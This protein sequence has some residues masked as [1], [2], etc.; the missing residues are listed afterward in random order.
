MELNLKENLLV[1]SFR[2]TCVN[3]PNKTRSFLEFDKF[4]QSQIR[5]SLNRGTTKPCHAYSYITSSK[6]P[7]YACDD[8]NPHWTD[9]ILG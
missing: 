2:A 6:L 8:K 4:I 3:N 1:R 5:G 9:I 7:C